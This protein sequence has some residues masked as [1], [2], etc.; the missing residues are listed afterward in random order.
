MTDTDIF[1][2]LFILKDITWGTQYFTQYPKLQ[3]KRY[4]RIAALLKLIRIFF[5]LFFRGN[6]F[7]YVYSYAGES[8][9]GHSAEIPLFWGTH[10]G[11]RWIKS[12]E[13]LGKT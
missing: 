9:P 7:Q 4:N 12:K 2:I 8:G 13:E 5:D 6:T 10:K 3:K 1:F 11:K